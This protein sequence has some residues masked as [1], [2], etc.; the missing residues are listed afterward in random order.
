MWNFFFM[1]ASH[2]VTFVFALPQGKNKI[3][4]KNVLME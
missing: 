2:I 3:V 4:N 1:G